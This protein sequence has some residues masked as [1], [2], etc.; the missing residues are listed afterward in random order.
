MSRWIS[1][2]AAVVLAALANASAAQAW[3]PGQHVE[4]V[5]PSGAGGGSDNV[6]RAI[7][8]VLRNHRLLEVPLTVVNRPGAGGD[9]AWKSL[10]Q[11]GNDA[12]HLS[13]LT[14]NL[15]SN[16]ITGRSALTHTDLT[17]VAQLFSEA[18]G[19][20]VRS[21]SPLKDGR[22]LLARLRA[23]PAGLTVAVGTAFGGSGHVA[24]ALAAKAAGGDAK[25]IKAVV[26]PAFGQAL[27]AM[28]GGHID[29][30]LNPHSSL[31]PHVQSGKVRALAVS[32]PQRVSGVLAD[33]PTLKELGADVHVEAFRAVV[34]P[35]AMTAAQAAYWE[36][37]FRRMTTTDEWRE[38]VQKR[39]WI[40]KF[41]GAEGCRN[42]LRFHYEQARIG[43]TELGLA[44][45]QP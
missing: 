30:V 19:V 42:G 40:D 11:P 18:S 22:E 36:G 1:V 43:L 15:L 33:V 3:K 41:A 31:V 39:G 35:K 9:I 45:A 21:D 34:G 16:H 5:S 37:V 24:I 2:A 10:N 20:G 13:L 14:A 7:E 32:V 26:F 8:R 17:C 6:V 27:A 29:V 4:F 25:K 38:D 44:K 23:D 28:L 12:H